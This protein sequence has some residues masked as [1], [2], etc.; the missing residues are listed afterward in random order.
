LTFVLVGAGPT[1]VE[2]AGALAILVRSTLR[3]EFRRV[4]PTSARIVRIDMAP[5]VL[6]PFAESL[7]AAARTRQREHNHSFFARRREKCANARLAFN[8]TNG[9][10]LAGTLLSR[11]RQ[12]RNAVDLS[13][14]SLIDAGRDRLRAE[15]PGAA[16]GDPSRRW[17]ALAL[18][19]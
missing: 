12:R 7:S 17:N 1:G 9:L 5:R 2:M 11:E 10:H 16:H 6:G 18:C 14:L 4:D 15:Q 3:S 8:R 13:N 19:C